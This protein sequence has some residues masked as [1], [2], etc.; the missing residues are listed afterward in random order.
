L[1]DRDCGKLPDEYVDYR[2]IRKRHQR[3]GQ[4]GRVGSQTTATTSRHDHGVHCYMR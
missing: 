1:L 4:N 3:L 2:P